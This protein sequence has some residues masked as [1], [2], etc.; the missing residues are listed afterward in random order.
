MQRIILKPL[1]IESCLKFLCS[2]KW[3]SILLKKLWT[4][5]T[6]WETVCETL[7]TEGM[8]DYFTKAIS[9][10]CVGSFH[11]TGETQRWA[12]EVV[13]KQKH[14]SSFSG[15]AATNQLQFLLPANKGRLKKKWALVLEE[16]RRRRI[17][18]HKEEKP[19]DVF[20]WVSAKEWS[21]EWYSCCCE[22][23]KQK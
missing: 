7:I 11:R 16:R 15:W 2:I 13:I 5:S 14:R 21:N 8:Y 9:R 3:I 4:L 6:V 23:Q 22:L 1:K 18:K 12:T 19:L 10:S 20:W 17:M